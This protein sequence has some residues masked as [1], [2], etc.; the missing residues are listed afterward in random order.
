MPPPPAAPAPAGRPSGALG[1]WIAVVAAIA[2]AA[3]G[4][5]VVSLVVSL[6]RGDDAAAPPAA[7]GNPGAQS[8]DQAGAQP[9]A[10]PAAGDLGA[11]EGA[12]DQPPAAQIDP[13]TV[14]GIAVGSGGAA[15]AAIPSE[16][17]VR[18]DTFYDFMC[19]YCAQFE[20]AYGA[21]LQRLVDEG[22]IILVQ[23]PLGFLDR[24]SMGTNYSSRTAQAAGVVAAQAPDVFSA[25]VEG[26]FAAQPEENSTGLDDSQIVAI[27]GEAG[28][29][30]TVSDTFWAADYMTEQSQNA[31]A[32]IDAGITG[33]PTVLISTPDTTP[34]KWD[35][36]TPLD[37]LVAQKAGQ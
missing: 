27:A 24:F 5:S 8:G 22:Q 6:N 3:L 19:P 37:Q 25:F 9:P 7:V 1:T 17:Q 28:V 14:P 10:D 18:I 35:Y 31:S 4:V 11:D 21:E 15:L 29:P 13:R 12:A 32:A 30:S 26:L 33:T 36:N 20:E 16:P 23:H 34:E 2:T